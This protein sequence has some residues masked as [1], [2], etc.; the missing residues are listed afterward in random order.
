MRCAIY[1]RKSGDEPADVQFSSLDSQRELCEKYIGSQAGEGWLALP[2]HY[3]DGGFSGGNLNRP[4]LKALLEDVRQRKIDIVVVY[5][6]DRLS[7]SLRDFLNLVTL[8]EAHNVTFVAVTQSFNTTTSMGR[9]MLNILLS[10]AQFERELTSDRLKDWFAGARAKGYWTNHRPYGYQ[11]VDHRLV[12][13]PDEAK[14]VRRVFARYPKVGSCRIVADELMSDGIVNRHG[15]PW[16]A[17]M[18][19][20][21]IKH[22]VYLGEVVH[23]KKGLPGTHEP[24]ISKTIWDKANKVYA[25]SRWRGRAFVTQPIVPLLKGLL[26]DRTGHRMH[27][28]FMHAKGRLYRYYIAGSE[29]LRYG[30]G[31]DPYMRLRAPEIEAG[32]LAFADRLTGT[33]AGNHRSPAEILKAVRRLIE[34][35]DVDRDAMTITLRTGAVFRIDVIGRVMGR[36][37]FHPQ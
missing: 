26:Y 12:I 37:Q 32:I 20:Y 25:T 11:V 4:A 19:G 5:K 30:P 23:R 27:H 16:Q 21:M 34:R 17:P 9:L 22:R 35:I 8:F 28:T 33:L 2:T 7:R 18:I 29:R 31:S 36:V 13:D 14:I 15:R 1:T 10:F 6:I 3:D 24:I